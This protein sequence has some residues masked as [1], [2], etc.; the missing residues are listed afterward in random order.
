ML[1]VRSFVASVPVVFVF[2]FIV[3]DATIFVLF[4]FLIVLFFVL[5]FV[6]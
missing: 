4:V 6:W 3:C 2:V 1:S 5:L